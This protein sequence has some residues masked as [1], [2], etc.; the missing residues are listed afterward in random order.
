MRKFIVAAAVATV[1]I[2]AAAPAFAQTDGRAP[3]T[4]P[5]VEAL[6]GWDHTN[7]NGG[8]KDGFVYGGALGY[9]VQRGGAVVGVEGEVTGST[10]KDRAYNVVN[11]NDSA[12]IG[13]GR[14]LY[15]GA[16]VGFAVAPTTLVYAKAGYTNARV[17]LD[18]STPQL[19][20]RD[21]QNLDG[22]RIGAG[23]EHLMPHNTYVKAE[24]RYSNY[25]HN[26]DYN[27]DAER[28]QILAGVGMRF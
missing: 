13:A 18:Y 22:Y 15:V 19:T 2:G 20:L 14:D 24:Y 27:L 4:G 1:A 28:H 10:T 17:N 25:G 21:H 9:D 7:I 5:R 23:V 16:R 8:K 6:A 3:F 11:A 26:D 12:R